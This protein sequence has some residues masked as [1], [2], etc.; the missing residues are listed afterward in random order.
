MK[1]DFVLEYCLGGGRIYSETDPPGENLYRNR[2]SGESFMGETLSRDTGV[3]VSNYPPFRLP[4]WKPETGSKL[5]GGNLRPASYYP[6]WFQI[7]PPYAYIGL[8]TCK[9][10]YA[11][12][13]RYVDDE[14]NFA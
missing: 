12:C 7:T 13:S 2:V 6:L 4:P 9:T 10:R 3:P 1:Y 11:Q 5:P 8:Y 14:K